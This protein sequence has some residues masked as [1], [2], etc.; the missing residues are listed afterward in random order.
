MNF[1]TTLNI[2]L[3]EKYGRRFAETFE[4]Y[5][6]SD[7]I[8]IIVFEGSEIEKIDKT[9]FTKVVFVPFISKSHEKFIKYFGNLYEANGYKVIENNT[10]YLGK[11]FK[12]IQD[13]RFNAVRFSFKIFSLLIA[14]NHLRCGPNFAWIDADVVCL[15]KFS[16]SELLPFMPD[17]Y[18]L[19]SYLGRTKFPSPNP[20]SECGFLGFNGNHPKLN[21]FL[22][23]MELFY[24]SGEI[25]SHKEWHDSWLWD[26]LRKEYENIGVLFKNIS[27]EFQDTWHPFINCGLGEYFDHL[28]GPLRKELGKS[29][30]ED[31]KR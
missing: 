30:D 11:Q 29:F 17:S 13:F 24:T 7:C 28:K 4:K 10:L 23:E 12:L 18:E 15:K 8:L 25:F 21:E 5:S 9:I 31:Y 27:Y 22:S 3:F 26:H 19:M 16:Q 20:Y 6:S 1:I 2:E 14:K